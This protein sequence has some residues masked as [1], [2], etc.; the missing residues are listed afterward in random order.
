MTYR[1]ARRLSAPGLAARWMALV[2]MALQFAFYADH[3]GADAVA[4]VGAAEPGARLGFLEICTGDG[5]VLVGPD[6]A[7]VAAPNDCPICQNASILAFATPFAWEAPVFAVVEVARLPR[8]ATVAAPAEAQFPGTKPI[9]GPP[10][11]A[12]A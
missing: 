10:G 8:V 3:I 9:R 12:L 6:G 1:A 4:G 5:V 7:P 11:A 2:A